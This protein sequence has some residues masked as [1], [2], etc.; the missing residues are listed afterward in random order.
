MLKVL[1]TQYKLLV[2]RE[3]HRPNRPPVFE[4]QIFYG[5]LLNIYEIRFPAAPQLRRNRPEVFVLARV[6]PCPI[7][8]G[9]IPN[10]IS[11][12]PHAHENASVEV[13]DIAMISAV[14]GRF[15]FE[16]RTYILDRTDGNCD[17]IIPTADM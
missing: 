1:I 6:Q 17:C 14:V 8:N 10:S 5:R 7:T 11:Y 3:A 15:N 2:D 16:A 12:L 13:I 4:E 9:P